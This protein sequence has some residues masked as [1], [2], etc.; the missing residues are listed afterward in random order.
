MKLNTFATLVSLALVGAGSISAQTATTDPV[1]FV[2]VDALANS[3][4]KLSTALSRA[5]SFVGV[6][7]TVS[8]NVVTVQGTPGW[9]NNQFVYA[10]GSQPNSYYLSI[11]GTGVK[12][13]MY[14][15]ITANGINSVTVNL[16]G[17]PSDEISANVPSG[18]PVRIMPHWTLATLFPGQAGITGTSNLFGVGAVTQ[19]LMTAGNVVGINLSA[20]ATYY[21]YTGTANV[22]PGW[23]KIGTN[24]IKRDDDIVEPDTYVIVRHNQTPASQ[25]T[26]T[27]N[28]AT[29][30][31]RTVIGTLLANTAQDN[32]IGIEV[33]VPLTLLQSN[34]FESGAF[35][36]STTKFGTNGDKLLVFDDGVAG[37]NKSASATYYYFPATAGGTPGW[38]KVGGG[39]DTI[40]DSETVFQPG[41]G[42][43]VR[44]QAAATAATVVWNIP[45][46]Y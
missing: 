22:G 21:Y 37:V 36:G 46:P 23:R 41:K 5:P 28:V 13:G 17:F 14:Y 1:G 15:D 24:S 3:D 2:T 27:G 35:V 20:S 8:G 25:I 33:P 29:T 10:A 9:T 34:L 44:K 6:V 19:I 45:L 30:I 12:A 43:V 18:T 39:F 42:Y 38:R 4:T 31:R 11:G 26:V 40:R 32:L 16:S 7:A